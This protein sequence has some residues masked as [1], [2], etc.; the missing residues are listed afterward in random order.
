MISM[1]CDHSMLRAAG[2]NKAPMRRVLDVIR[3]VSAL[4]CSRSAH[5]SVVG[6]GPTSATSRLQHQALLSQCNTGRNREMRY[7]E[8][9]ITLLRTMTSYVR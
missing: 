7:F 3:T 2:L 6:G 4:G 5:C 1:R 9:Q 8:K